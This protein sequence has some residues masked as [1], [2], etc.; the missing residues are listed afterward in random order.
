MKKL[1]N[2]LFNCTEGS[3]SGS[4][5]RLLLPLNSE[6]PQIRVNRIQDKRFNLYTISLVQSK[7]ISLDMHKQKICV[8]KNFILTKNYYIPRNN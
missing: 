1:L 2:I 7:M 4:A 3:K 8:A 5:H 6:V